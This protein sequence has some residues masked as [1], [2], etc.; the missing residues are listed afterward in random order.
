MKICEANEQTLGG[1]KSE[2]IKFSL[3]SPPRLALIPFA[4]L[5]LPRCQ[6]SRF[7]RFC[8]ASSLASVH[9][10]IYTFPYRNVKKAGETGEILLCARQKLDRRNKLKIDR[11]LG[12]NAESKI[13]RLVCI[14]IGGQLLGRDINRLARSWEK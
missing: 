1:A 7:I 14:S 10:R 13:L 8:R 5:L 4:V 3:F 12:I 9:L 2:P 11:L 6:A